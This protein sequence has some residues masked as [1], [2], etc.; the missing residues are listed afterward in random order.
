M[1]NEG[2]RSSRQMPSIRSITTEKD[3]C[4]LL[5]AWIQ[6]NSERVSPNRP[7]R[8]IEKKKVKFVE[9]EKHFTREID[10]V[11]EKTMSKYSISKYFKKLVDMGLI[12][13]NEDDKQNYYLA[14]LEP[15]EAMLIEVN[16]LETL[17][18]TMERHVI[19]IYSYLYNRYFANGQSSYTLT[20]SQV[21]DFIGIATTTTSNNY[22]IVCSFE[23]LERLG[24]LSFELVWKDG[25][26]FYQ[27]NWVRNKL[28]ALK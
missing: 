15:D 17:M 10:G 12:Y 5:Y 1:Y 8:K 23:I 14:L 19:D 2:I 18:N 25:L 13:E 20:L 22:R 11:V 3:Y 27:I 16:T 6:T 7:D 28:P 21:K 4:D 9:I 24:L 26:S